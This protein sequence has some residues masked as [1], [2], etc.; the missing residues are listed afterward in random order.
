MSR[1][2][3]EVVP[4][5]NGWLIRMPGDGVSELCSSKPQAIQRARELG[6]RHDTWR[7]RVLTASGDVETELSSTDTSTAS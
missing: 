2:F 4:E 6:R 5:P 1:A 3:F 7:V